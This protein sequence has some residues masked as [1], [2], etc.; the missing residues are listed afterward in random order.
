MK[1]KKISYK[2]LYAILTNN[3]ISLSK[4]KSTDIIAHKYILSKNY[5]LLGLLKYISNNLRDLNDYENVRV[6]RFSDLPVFQFK[7]KGHDIVV[8][9]TFHGDNYITFD[10]NVIFN[11]E[12]TTIIINVMFKRNDFL[13]N[14]RALIET[15]KMK[16]VRGVF[17]GL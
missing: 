11:D 6:S 4:I 15:C 8:A 17:E 9:H 7:Y 5:N 3:I 2:V 14:E 10:G 1:F 13:K 16:Q 12:E